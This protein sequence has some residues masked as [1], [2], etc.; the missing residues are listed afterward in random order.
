MPSCETNKIPVPGRPKVLLCVSP[1]LCENN[2]FFLFY[3]LA[4]TQRTNRGF[5]LPLTPTPLPAEERGERECGFLTAWQHGGRS[6]VLDPGQ[7]PSRRGLKLMEGFEMASNRI[8]GDFGE[9]LWPLRQIVM[10]Q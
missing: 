9:I 5:L 3:F 4:E 8:F 2:L 10:A 7:H 6:M 1:R